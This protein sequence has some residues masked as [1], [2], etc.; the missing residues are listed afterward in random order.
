MSLIVDIQ[1]TRGDTTGAKTRA[2]R[3]ASAIVGAVGAGANVL[4]AP[5]NETQLWLNR[6]MIASS[7]VPPFLEVIASMPLSLT[8]LITV[9]ISLLLVDLISSNGASLAFCYK[10]IE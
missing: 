8:M 1:A 4:V 5:D 9:S 2:G 7:R 10:N 3:A 6:V